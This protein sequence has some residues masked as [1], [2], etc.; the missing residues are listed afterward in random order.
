MSSD[1]GIPYAKQYI[2]DD[3][4]VYAVCPRCGQRIDLTGQKDWESPSLNAYQ[5]HY[6]THHGNQD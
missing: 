1:I 2:T 6:V 4:Q 3:G 5:Q